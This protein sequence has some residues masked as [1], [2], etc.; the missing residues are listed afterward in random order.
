LGSGF[1]PTLGG[2]FFTTFGY[3]SSIKN[4][5]TNADLEV[6]TFSGVGDIT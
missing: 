5:L 1:L 3:S 4:S 6:S 2:G